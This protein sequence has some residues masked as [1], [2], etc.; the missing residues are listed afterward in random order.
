VPLY[1]LIKVPPVVWAGALLGLALAWRPALLFG[2]DAERAPSPATRREIALLAF[3]VVFP[4]LCQVIGHGPA[5]TGMRHF[6][7]VLPPLAVL[8]GTGFDALI[9][10][11]EG[12]VQILAHAASATLAAVLLWN[13][14]LLV[15]LHPDQ[16]LYYSP[17][18]GGLR[19]AAQR[20]DTD[21]WVNIMPEAVETLE[22]YL[23]RTE[24]PLHGVPKHRYMV[25]VCGE[26][27]A[28]EKEADG[29]LKWTDGWREAD[30]FIAPTHMHCDRA[31]DGKT[32]AT[33]ERLGVPI[34]VVKDRRSLVRPD[35]ARD[36]RRNTVPRRGS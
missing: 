33:I 4:P 23:N 30:F 15:A 10:A 26:R 8:A 21:Y 13:V 14:G 31:A 20:Y 27:L 17:L 18:V 16:Y 34:G 2:P 11:L 12:R 9:T 5:F 35:I 29:R 28:F 19:G 1:L 36:R 24:G 6:L 25:G 3:M 32:I 7:F 22:T